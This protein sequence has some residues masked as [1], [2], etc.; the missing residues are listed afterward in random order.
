MLG[1]DLIVPDVLPVGT[2][3]P[4]LVFVYLTNGEPTRAYFAIYDPASEPTTPV[5]SIDES[6]T[7]FASHYTGFDILSLGGIS[8]GERTNEFGVTFV[9]EADGIYFMVNGSWP[10]DELT[11]AEKRDEVLRIAESM[12][13]QQQ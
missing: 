10:N 1:F 5:F 4:D 12:I 11:L 3:L 7:P 8:V 2:Q 6:L 9:W 13:A